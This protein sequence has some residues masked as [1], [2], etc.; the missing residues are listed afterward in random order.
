MRVVVVV[1]ARTGSTR[2]PGKA[3]LPL[4]GRPLLQR[5]LERVAAA[6]TPFDVVIATT[7]GP[8]DQIIRALAGSMGISCYSGHPTGLLYRHCY[9]ARTKRADVVV[10]IPSDCPLV[11]PGVIDRVLGAFLAANGTYDYGSNLHPA[12]YPDGN[13]VEVMTMDALEA[14]HQEAWRAY[15]REHTTPF[16]WDRPDRFRL[17][18]LAWGTGRDYSMSHRFTIDYPED[19]GFVS[20][21]YNELW[22]ERSPVFRL[23][24]ILLDLA[25]RHPEHVQ[26]GGTPGI[27]GSGPLPD[28]IPCRTLGRHGC[29][30]QRA[31]AGRRRERAGLLLRGPIREPHAAGADGRTRTL[32]G[33]NCIPG[34]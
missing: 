8:E 30:G 15:E 28:E 19:F 22:S 23:R 25:G 29:A 6:D 18:N 3:I 33:S 9:A 12:T 17:L 7:T 10:R 13:D 21:V 2:L 20:A 32:R 14:A 16:I 26:G 11:D 5:M 1:P 31:V 34:R 4:R 27:Q 24:E